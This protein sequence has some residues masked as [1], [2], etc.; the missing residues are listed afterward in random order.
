VQD[1]E[2][3]AGSDAMNDLSVLKGESAQLYGLSEGWQ[4]I[5]SKLELV[6]VSRHH[7]FNS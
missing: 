1:L 2:S 6:D 7:I 5:K 4:N 3:F